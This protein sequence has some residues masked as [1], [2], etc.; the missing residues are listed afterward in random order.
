MF[1]FKR[2]SKDFQPLRLEDAY[3]EMFKGR[4]EPSKSVVA[5]DLLSCLDIRCFGATFAMKAKGGDNIAISIHGPVQFNHGVNIWKEN[6]IFSEQ[7]MS[8]FA[9]KEGADASTLGS[10]SKLQE[11]HYLHHI[12]VNPKNLDEIVRLAGDNAMPLSTNDITKLKQALCFGAT[13]FDSSAK[14]GID[15]E[16]LVWVTLKE[17]AKS[18]LPTFNNLISLDKKGDKTIL[19]LEALTAAIDRLGTDVAS[20]ELHYLTESVNMIN[21]PINAKH[22]DISSGKEIT[23]S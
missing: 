4:E 8:P 9:N 18:V 7:I 19:N 3:N 17:G 22:F 16:A 5:N 10:Q 14:A 6:H 12:S 20:V 15:N 11:G 23:K 2:L 13:Y 21:S 1:Y